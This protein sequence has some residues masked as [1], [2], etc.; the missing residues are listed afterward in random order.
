[1]KVWLTKQDDKVKTQLKTQKKD[2]IEGGG[3]RLN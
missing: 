3:V 2:A 1:M